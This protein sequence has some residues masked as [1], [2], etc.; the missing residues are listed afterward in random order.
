[1]FPHGDRDLSAQEGT[2]SLDISIEQEKETHQGGGLDTLW[3]PVAL[4]WSFLFSYDFQ[5]YQRRNCTHTTRGDSTKESIDRNGV[6]PCQ[7]VW[8]QELHS[9]LHGLS[10][11]Q[12]TQGNHSA[13]APD[14]WKLARTVLEG[15]IMQKETLA[16]NMRKEHRSQRSQHKQARF[17]QTRESTALQAV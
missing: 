8:G 12:P 4:A 10:P 11:T 16:D 7:T 3:A 13:Y 17:R 9:A 1:M 14:N 5:S 15:W 6:W 2:A